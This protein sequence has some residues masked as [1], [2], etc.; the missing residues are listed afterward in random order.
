MIGTLAAKVP[1]ILATVDKKNRRV[2]V[3]RILYPSGDLQADMAEIYAFYDGFDG[4]I[5]SNYASPNK[6]APEDR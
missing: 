4:L 1:I 5:A 3:G 6:P 2:G